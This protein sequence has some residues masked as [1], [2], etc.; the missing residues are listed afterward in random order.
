MGALFAMR[1]V[2]TNERALIEWKRRTGLR[3]IGTSPSARTDYQAVDYTRKPVAL[4]LGGERE[5]MAPLH[6]GLCDSMVRIPMV[7]RSD[8][9]NVGIAAGVL[10]YEAFNQNRK[11]VP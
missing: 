8:S 11:R 5:G 2:R 6:Q 9:L 1:V 4:W 7:G 10:L 3:L